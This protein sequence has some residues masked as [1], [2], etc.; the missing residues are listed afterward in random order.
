MTAGLL[1]ALL[2]QLG[3]YLDNLALSARSAADTLSDTWKGYR[4]NDLRLRV[5][6]PGPSLGAMAEAALDRGFALA[7]NL[8]AG[9]NLE[10][11]ISKG[12][13]Q[14]AD[15]EQLFERRGW[16]ADPSSYHRDPPPVEEVSL[17][18]AVSQQGLRRLQYQQLSYP[19]LYEPWPSEPGRE[20]W[21][22]MEPNR[23]FHAYVLRYP[24][25]PRPWLVCVHGFGM[26]GPLTAF[27]GFNARKLHSEL[28]L[29]LAFPVLPLHG[30][31]ALG[32]ASGRELL[33]ADFMTMVYCFAQAAWD[34]R[35]L[36][37]WLKSEDDQPVGLYGLSL[38]SLAASLTSGLE[39][40]DCVIAGIPA[41]DFAGLVRDNEISIPGRKPLASEQGYQRLARVTSVI[42][43]LSFAP[44]VAR[45]KRFIFAGLADRLARPYQADALWRHWERPPVHWFDGAHV[46]YLMKSSVQRFVESSLA[47]A[48]LTW[49]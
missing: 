26:G 37:G 15:A 41:V 44:Q 32:R 29:N 24:G 21:Q 47:T 11:R 27:T 39:P 20:R 9:R 14:L 28:G 33:A 6:R 38:G 8:A 1:R 16:L 31:R 19:S 45:D 35:R 42:N 4:E 34:L 30:P 40:V 7:A 18:R 13:A 12:F 48:G 3:N 46:T 10:E 49:H 23:R 43:P 36:V 5:P 17:G 22:A 25:P 2:K